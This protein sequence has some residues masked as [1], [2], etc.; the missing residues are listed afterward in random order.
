MTNVEQPKR[1]GFRTGVVTEFTVMPPIKPGEGQAVRDVIKKVAENPDRQKAVREIGT[2]HEARFV[3]FDDDSHVLFCSSFDGTWD[4][5]IDDFATTYI[6]HVF[7]AVFSHCEGFPGLNDPNIKDWFQL[8]AVTASNFISAYP[9]LTVQQIWKDQRVNE[10][11]QA[12]L[13]TPEF[14]A[15]LDNPANAALLATPAFQKLLDVAAG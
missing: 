11:F 8:H 15:A 10:A 6:A 4:K 5:Y 2:L 9:D 3:V 12:V 14:R 7:D 1:K 13:D